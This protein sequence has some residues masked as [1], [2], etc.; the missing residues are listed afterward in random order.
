MLALH[1]GYEPPSLQQPPSHLPGPLPL[2]HIG[3]C[4]KREMP[5]IFVRDLAR[6]VDRAHDVRRDHDHEFGLADLAVLL[7]EHIADERNVA[8]ERY[9]LARQRV[10]LLDEPAEHQ[11]FAVA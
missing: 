11:E 6:L 3:T 4:R 9:L 8:E 5:P 10:A 1:P 2:A 7:L